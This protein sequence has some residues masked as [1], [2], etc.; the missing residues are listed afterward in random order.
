M[1]SR[2][3][4]GWIALVLAGAVALSAPLAAAAQGAKSTVTI[5]VPVVQRLDGTTALMVSSNIS[6]QRDQLVVK[7]NIPWVLVAHASGAVGTVTW[8][9]VGQTTWQQVGAA[10]PVLE[11]LKGIRPV[12]YEVQLDPGAQQNG[13]RILL[14][15][16]VEPVGAH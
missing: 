14:T 2:V 10:T 13:S 5:T 7:S 11:G 1:F 6:Q 4:S 9:I 16:S 8:R 3:Q 15:F 12:H